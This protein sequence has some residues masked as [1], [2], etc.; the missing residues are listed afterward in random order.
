MCRLDDIR[1]IGVVNQSFG[2]FVLDVINVNGLVV[3]KL[4][5]GVAICN[6]TMPFFF[7]QAPVFVTRTHILQSGLTLR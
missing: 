6:I 5:K 4:L 7:E 3:Q 1:T 2:V